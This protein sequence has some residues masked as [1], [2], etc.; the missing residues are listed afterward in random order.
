MLLPNLSD[1]PVEPGRLPQCPSN[2]VGKA[3]NHISL[4]LFNQQDVNSGLKNE[5][6]IEATVII[7]NNSKQFCNGES[8]LNSAGEGS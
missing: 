5:C 6:G 2:E 4:V 7:D 3:N 1:D 8:S